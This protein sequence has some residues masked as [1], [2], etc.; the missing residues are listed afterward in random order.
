M[1]LIALKAKIEI[2]GAPCPRGAGRKASD[3]LN[4]RLVADIERHDSK[5]D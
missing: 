4:Q 2:V 3:P 5:S 1:Q